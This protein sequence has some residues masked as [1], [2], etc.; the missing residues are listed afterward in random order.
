MLTFKRL[1]DVK[2]HHSSEVFMKI[3]LIE[4]DKM[5]AELIQ[6]ILRDEN[7]FC[8]IVAN[9]EE[10]LQIIKV[11]QYDAIVLDLAL[12]DINGYEILQKFR[13]GSIRTPILVLS[14]YQST[15]DKVRALGFGADDY[16]T[17]PFIAEELIVRLK[18]LIRRSEGHASAIVK[19]G[20][21]EL[22]LDAQCILARGIPL[23]LTGKEYQILEFL[24]LR[25]N[26][27]VTKSNFLNHLYSGM[28]EPE[29]KIIDVFMCKIRRKLQDVLG[30]DG[31]QYIETVW[32]RGYVIRDPESL[33]STSSYGQSN[34]QP[35][36]QTNYQ[37]KAVGSEYSGQF[38]L[39]GMGSIPMSNQGQ[40]NM[41]TM[42]FNNMAFNN[43]GGDVSGFNNT[44]SSNP[45]NVTSPQQHQE[46][47]NMTS[48][49]PFYSSNSGENPLFQHY[50]SPY[51]K[52][53]GAPNNVINVP[54]GEK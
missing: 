3:L 13:D 40:S 14:G 27:T 12:P 49:F 41:N 52:N 16:V 39:M 36:P 50:G 4:D 17:K 6:K 54:T 28:D 15:Q 24:L 5:T 51:G 7:L 1:K 31:K 25:K 38:P 47:N 46:Y 32:G 48:Q 42:A 33:R 34:I 11:Y 9:G 35:F 8:D 43:T 37:Q 10:A 44:A 18:A 21:L 45:L 19:V 2:I 53:Q 26:S 23:E 29:E 20:E 30:S 22:N